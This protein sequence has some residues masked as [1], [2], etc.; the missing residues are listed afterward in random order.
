MKEFKFWAIPYS[1]WQILVA[2]ILM[3]FLLIAVISLIDMQQYLFYLGP[4][5]LVWVVLCGLLFIRRVRI[6]FSDKNDILVFMN[7]WQKYVGKIQELE[8]VR[9]ANISNNRGRASLIMKF[10]DKK[11]NFSILEVKNVLSLRDNQQV[12]L[13]KYMVSAF[14]LQSEVYQ[15]TFLNQIYT[16]WNPE[17]EGKIASNEYNKKER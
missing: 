10:A 6:S 8:Y 17:Y 5:M 9:G 7:G 16:Y 14:K 1:F 3:W 4:T 15:D 12:R 13:L 2:F 11:L